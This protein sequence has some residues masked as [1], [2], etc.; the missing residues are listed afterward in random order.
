MTTKAPLRLLPKSMIPK[1]IVCK[2]C[3]EETGLTL[4]VIMKMTIDTH[5]CCPLCGTM[6]YSCL[7]EKP[8]AYVYTGQSSHIYEYD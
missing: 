2:K 4:D 6:I 5:I 3:N 7:P 8:A 1:S